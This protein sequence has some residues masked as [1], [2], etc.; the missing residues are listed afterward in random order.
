[1]TGADDNRRESPHGHGRVAVIAG[2]GALPRAIVRTLAA[3]GEN[4]FV[5]VVAG[6][7]GDEADFAGADHVVMHVEEL[8]HLLSRLKQANVGRLVMAGSVSRRPRLRAIRWSFS[9]LALL[10]R[11]AAALKRGDDGLLRA[12]IDILE[13]NGIRVVGAREVVPDL[14][15]PEGNLTRA[16]PT[17]ADRCDIAAASD[18][19]VALGRLDIGQGAIAIGGRVVALEGIEGTD[20]LLERMAGMRGH[21]RL[22]GKERGV[23]V[24]RCKP[25]QEHRADLPAIGPDTIDGAHAAGLAGVAVDAGRSFILDFDRTMARADALGLFVVGLPPMQEQGR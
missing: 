19:A 24:K 2:G 5:V 25:Q 15:A 21:G 12:V 10:P 6:E 17:A 16:Q 4:P 14:L 3:A 11:A 7:D 20:G 18:A 23:L 8:G 9:A 13:E 1:M 22:A